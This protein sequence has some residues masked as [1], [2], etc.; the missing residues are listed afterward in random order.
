MA[1]IRSHKT[2][3]HRV[4][5]T[6]SGYKLDFPGVTTTSFAGLT[7][8]KCFIKVTVLTPDAPFLTLDIQNIY[9]NTP[10]NRYNY[11]KI[12]LSVIPEEIIT[13]YNLRALATDG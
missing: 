2:E 13:Q 6:V 4:R 5:V 12:S 3:T 7:T 1:S 9:Y 10:M 11:M 8:T